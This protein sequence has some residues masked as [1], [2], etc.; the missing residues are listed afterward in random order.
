VE[1]KDGGNGGSE[2]KSFE[3][4]DSMPGVEVNRSSGKRLILILI[5]FFAGAAVMIIEIAA[6][7]VLAPW[8]GNTIFT[9]T[10]LIGVILLALSVG[11]YVGGRLADYRCDDITLSHLLALSSMTILL[12]PLFHLTVGKYLQN[13]DSILGPILASALLFALPGFLLGT[14]SPYIIRLVSLQSSDRHIGLS[15]GTI[16]M[17]STLGGVIGTFS[18]GFFLV[19]RIQLHNVFVFVAFTMMA[20]S[21]IG[22]L[23]HLNQ[24][25]S[26]LSLL[27]LFIVNIL[28]LTSYTIIRPT[29][30]PSVIYDQ[31]TFYHRIRVYQKE[32]DKGD[33]MISLY[34]D[35]A[36]EG[37]RYERSQQIP[38]K[39]QR[40]WELSRIFSP[41]LERAAFLG[42]GA[43]VMPEALI[44]SRSTVKVDVIEV[45]PQLIEVGRRFFK[46]DEYPQ[47]HII[48]DDARRYLRLT[49]NK[50]DL[51]FADVYHGFRTVPAHLITKEFFSLIKDRLNDRG[52]FMMNLIG[53]V[54]GY[55]SLL[56]K[57]ILNTIN[58]SFN[59]TYV[60][61]IDPNKL[62]KLQNIIIVALDNNTTFSPTEIQKPG[63]IALTSSLLS[64]YI[65]K[66]KY[67]LSGA[68]VFTDNYNPVEYLTAKSIY[69]KDN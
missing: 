66:D 64:H 40:Y 16:F 11:Y 58:T 34:L 69:F 31:N 1:G 10:G 8:F 20:L 37:A 33:K 27:L 32:V 44:R 22:Y 53:S 13:A 29:N 54:H 5:A 50:Y 47:M 2:Q 17:F 39:Y 28:L 7:R 62:N 61:A 6:N 59:Q 4:F 24:N 21:M 46:I 48:I 26:L 25:E 60:F 55:N 14:L 67:D 35:T 12:I 36:F 15:T 63:N 42:A 3:S 19:P 45:D 9:W 43:F 49:K 23:F 18:A 30:D 65:S 57:S 56:F 51:I 38:S 68:Y 52:V 41:Q